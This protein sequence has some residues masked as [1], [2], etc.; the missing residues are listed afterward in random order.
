MCLASE[1]ILA[2]NLLLG[3]GNICSREVLIEGLKK[4]GGLDFKAVWEKE[5]VLLY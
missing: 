1:I 4:G 3:D 5:G 2:I